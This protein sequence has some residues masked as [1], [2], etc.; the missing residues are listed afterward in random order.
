MSKKLSII[1]Q[2]ENSNNE[3][4]SVE[5]VATKTNVTMPATNFQGRA[6]VVT[7]GCAKN[8]VDSEVMLGVL[9]NAGYELVAEVE[10][11]DVAIVNT[12]SFLESAVQESIDCILDV[13]DLK[14]SGQLRKLI[15]AGCAVSRFKEDL[16][17]SMP[18]VD[19]FVS[20]DDLLQVGKVADEKSEL[21]DLFGTAARPYF[22]YDETMPRELSGYKHSAYVKVSEGCNRPCAFCIIPKIRGAFRSRQIPSLVSEVLDL[23]QRG[24]REINLVAQDLTAFGTDH[25][26]K[27]RLADLLYALDS[28]KAVDWVRLL[29]AYPIGVDEKL[30]DTIVKLPSVCNYLDIP[31]QHA[32][33]DVLK[34]MQRPVG[35]YSPTSIADFIK[36]KQPDIHIRTTFIVG[37]PGETEKDVEEL[38]NFVSQGYFSSVGVFT[39]SAEEG[40]PAATMPG[41]ISKKEKALR[42]SAVM[43]AQKEVV[44]KQL[45]KFINTEQEV[46][47]DGTHVDSDLILSGRTRFQA[48][49]VDGTVIVNDSEV[50]INSITNG[51]IC[52][53]RFTEVAEYDLVGTITKIV[54]PG[55]NI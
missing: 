43:S 54:K 44:A 28:T 51:A 18:E 38:V 3:S 32:S 25:T 29:Y 2:V 30:L 48:P 24:V 16:R 13:S 37:F 5:A 53:V 34:A 6:A 33:I 23:G 27:D 17:K 14:K 22:L 20:L 41:Q 31:L 35:R 19:A 46:L 8:Q 39:Y 45:E 9:K 10:R 21:K 42:Q 11:A 1:G 47:I 40:T 12:C 26:T 50:D 52:S 49:E 4:C 36:S 55:I 15:V 7:L